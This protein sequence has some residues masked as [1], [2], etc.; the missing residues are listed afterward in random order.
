[1][2]ELAQVIQSRPLFAEACRVM[3]KCFGSRAW[4]LQE[5]SF[6]APAFGSMHAVY[7]CNSKYFRVVW[8]GRDATV[9][10]DVADGHKPSEH[11]IWSD[12]AFAKDTSSLAGVAESVAYELTSEA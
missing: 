7:R 8:D 10:V 3:L 11:H 12:L 5:F 4:E 2:K 6:N 9:S 1:M